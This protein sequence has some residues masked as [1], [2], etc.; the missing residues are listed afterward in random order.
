M[1]V[2]SAIVTNFLTLLFVVDFI[3][4]LTIIFLERKNPSATLAWIMVLF[5][6]PVMGIVFYFLFSQN[7]SRQKMFKLSKS[8]EAVMENALQEQIEEIKMKTVI[9]IQ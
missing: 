4:A 9:L 6:L 3:I 7:I 8:E 2:W 1:I 5:L